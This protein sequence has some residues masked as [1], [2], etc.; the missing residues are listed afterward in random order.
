[1]FTGDMT[2]AIE[3]FEVFLEESECPIRQQSNISKPTKSIIYE[4]QQGTLKHEARWQQ[5]D[6]AKGNRAAQSHQ[7]SP[8]HIKKSRSHIKAAEPLE[9]YEQEYF[10]H[11]PQLHNLSC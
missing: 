5:R 4:Y 8:A 6:S 11:S 2:G 9:G 1:M 7:S 10:K 3:Q